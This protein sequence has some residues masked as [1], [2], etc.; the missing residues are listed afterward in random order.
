MIRLS[1]ETITEAYDETTDVVNLL[2]KTEQRLMDINDKNFRSDYHPMGDFVT[3][4]MDQIKE[5]GEKSDGLSGLESGFIGLDRMTAGFQPGTLIILAAHHLR[6]PRQS[7]PTEA[8]LRHPD[9]FHRLPA[10][11]VEWQQRHPQRQP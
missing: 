8:A 2:D 7:P 9:D 1:T 4:A 6:A 10:T 11:H 5:A 3:M